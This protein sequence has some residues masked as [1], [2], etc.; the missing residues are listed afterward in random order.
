[1]TIEQTRARIQARVWQHLAQNELSLKELP[2]EELEALVDVVTDA[3][4]LE[5]DKDLST[6]AEK[7]TPQEAVV[8]GVDDEQILWQG[9]PFLSINLQYIITNERVRIISGL[10]GKDRV[11]IELVRIQSFD[12]SQTVRERMLNLGDI[13]IHSHD[14]SNP[15]IT[16]NNIPNPEA[17]HEILRRAVLAARER[18]RLTY[19]EEM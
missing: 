13:V 2:R 14:R 9:R 19:R 12:Q 7:V 16:L 11:D 10:L 5:V 4:L 18:Y 17:V 1:M 8:A 15:V 3:A 6:E